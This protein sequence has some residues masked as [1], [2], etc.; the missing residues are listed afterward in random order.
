M[1]HNGLSFILFPIGD[2]SLLCGFLWFEW[3]SFPWFIGFGFLPPYEP[4]PL[5][6]GGGRIFVWNFDIFQSFL[7][8]GF[9]LFKHSFWSL[10]AHLSVN[11]Q[12]QRSIIDLENLRFSVKIWPTF[13]R[14]EGS[15][16]AMLGSKKSFSGLF[17]SC[18]EVV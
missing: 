1:L 9:K 6:G 10:K 7:E 8:I 18:L 3:L 16:L 12:V 15:F 14:F 11:F 17:Q 4:W 13:D 2:I 5:L